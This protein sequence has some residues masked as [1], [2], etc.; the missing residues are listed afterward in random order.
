MLYVPFADNQVKRV[1]GYQNNCGLN[2]I[3]HQF[4]NDLALGLQ[5]L[6]LEESFYKKLLN[7]FRAYH[8][9][10]GLTWPELKDVL[11]KNLDHPITLEVLMGPVLRKTLGD[12]LKANEQNK[13][14]RSHDFYTFIRA[15]LQ[16]PGNIDNTYF[17]MAEA[18]YPKVAT[19]AQEFEEFNKRADVL[20]L[21]NDEAKLDQ[22]MAEKEHEIDEYWDTTGYNGYVDFLCDPY[23]EI[24]LAPEDVEQLG[25]K[26]HY[27]LELYQGAEKTKL[28]GGS[29]LPNPVATI[30]M[31]NRAG[32]HYEAIA[33]NED[34][35]AIHNAQFNQQVDDFQRFTVAKMEY[36][37]KAQI[38]NRCDT[39][40]WQ[41]DQTQHGLLFN[42][43]NDILSRALDI[44]VSD[45]QFTLLWDNLERCVKEGNSQKL[46]E[47]E[48]T[49]NDVAKPR[50][51]L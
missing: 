29:Q 12:V 48:K 27:N 32:V 2:V 8:F 35:A 34:V 51:K 24:P 9:Q 13:A 11:R 22:F 10:P 26:L 31:Y 49:V 43:A 14:G 16:N 40:T 3:A 21:E 44:G 46:Q 42:Q 23:N 28:E 36:A 6:H 18:C 25:T 33:E 1:T 30:R 45:K 4:T 15:A 20:T 50:S 17:A 39:S 7:H 47:I 5:D 41:A 19:L 37:G 38:L